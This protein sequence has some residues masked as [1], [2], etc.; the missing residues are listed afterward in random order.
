MLQIENPESFLVP[1]VT[2]ENRQTTAFIGPASY[3]DLPKDWACDWISIWSYTDF[4]CQAIVKMTEGSNL[5]G[6][7]R[8]SLYPYNPDNGPSKPEF[9]FI[10]NIEAHPARRRRSKYF[11][12]KK[13]PAAPTPF[14]NPVGKWLIWYA[15]KTALDY[16]VVGEE[17]VL[18]LAADADAVDYYRDIVGI[19]MIDTGLSSIGEDSYAFSFNRDQAQN[20]CNLQRAAFGDP[21]AASAP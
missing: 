16:C 7:M 4:D 11:Y 3:S 20:F 15:C 17:S 6:L 1:T 10:E 21:K 8:Y 19:P 18:G 5:W 12:R 2:S 9:L 13:P 14:I